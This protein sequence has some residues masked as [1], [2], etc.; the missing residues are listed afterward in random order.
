LGSDLTRKF[1]KNHINK[2]ED[3][4]SKKHLYYE[5]AEEFY[6]VEQM[7]IKEIELKLKL[8]HS[9]ISAWK[10]DGKWDVKRIKFVASKKSFHEGLEE[11]GKK[12]LY[13]LNEDFNNGKKPDTGRM[14]AF[15]RMLPLIIKSIKNKNCEQEA[16]LD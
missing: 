13:S 4:L 1:V 3:N 7:T 2:G 12:L 9:T 6:V 5:Q 10:K 14:Y 15:T 8:S 16:N 11:F